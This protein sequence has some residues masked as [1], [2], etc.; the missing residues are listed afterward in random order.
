MIENVKVGSTKYITK[1]TVVNNC[2]SSSSSDIKHVYV[3]NLMKSGNTRIQLVTIAHK[4][5]D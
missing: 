1:M 4:Q 3:F 5:D 2:D